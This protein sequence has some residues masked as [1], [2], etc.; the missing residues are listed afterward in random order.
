M[1]KTSNSQRGRPVTNVPHPGFIN[2][3]ISFSSKIF[4]PIMHDFI[5]Q[6]KMSTEHRLAAHMERYQP[7]DQQQQLRVFSLFVNNPIAQQELTKAGKSREE[8][9]LGFLARYD[10]KMKSR[11]TKNV[12]KYFLAMTLATCAQA[13]A[14]TH[15]HTHIF[16]L[17]VYLPVS[18]SLSLSLSRVRSRTHTS[19]HAR[20][21]AHVCI[22]CM[23]I[24]D[25][26]SFIL[27]AQCIPI[28]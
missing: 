22:S 18:I 23:H 27:R 7:L 3:H 4:E 14:H 8:V 28:M 15:T 6:L 9:F 16:P 2:K 13:R 21:H 24:R 20:T 1:L 19:T 12:Q 5:A 26:D 25:I 17:S 11:L 10:M